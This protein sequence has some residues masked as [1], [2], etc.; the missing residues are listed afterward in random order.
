MRDEEKWVALHTYRREVALGKAPAI[1]CP[2]CQYEL[3]PVVTTD[4]QPSLK[5]LSCRSVFHI[6]SDTWD[7]I[8]ANIHELA[9]NLKKEQ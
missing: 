8:E 9:E 5:C 3:V 6:G 2:D 7:Q 1:M 4:T